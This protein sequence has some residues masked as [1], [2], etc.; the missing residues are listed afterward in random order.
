MDEKDAK[1]KIENTGNSEEISKKKAKAESEKSRKKQT[2]VNLTI[3]L[4]NN[5]I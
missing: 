5:F 2:L 1:R 3:F 4:L